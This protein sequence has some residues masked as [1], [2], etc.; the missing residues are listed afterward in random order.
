MTKQIIPPSALDLF[1]RWHAHFE[2]HEIKMEKIG[3]SEGGNSDRFFLRPTR[4]GIPLRYKHGIPNF[5]YVDVLKACLRGPTSIDTARGIA[6]NVQTRDEYWRLIN[7]QLLQPRKFFVQ[8]YPPHFP[9]W[10]NVQIRE[11]GYYSARFRTWPALGRG[12]V[13]NPRDQEPWPQ[14]H[15]SSFVPEGTP[16]HAAIAAANELAEFAHKD[17]LKPTQAQIDDLKE[18]VFEKVKLVPA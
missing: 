8:V 7:E 2:R 17:G 11:N 6:P 5:P 9:D 15:W 18:K 14:L 4:N 16:E 1:R 13:I 12:L 3:F 10:S